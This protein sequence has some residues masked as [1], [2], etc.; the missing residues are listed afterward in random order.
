MTNLLNGKSV[1]VIINDRGPYGKGMI[2]DVSKIA[3]KELDM[4]GKGMVPC[5][6][7]YV[8]P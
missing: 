6:I 3:A 5:S 1:D 4:F 8:K 2:I 7:S